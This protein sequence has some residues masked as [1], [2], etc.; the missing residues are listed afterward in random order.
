LAD[1]LR[2]EFEAEVTLEKGRGGVFDVRLAGSLLFSK[3]E[4]ERFPEPGE[5]SSLIREAA[6]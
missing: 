6:E 2:E 4:L 3:H 5:V 1:E